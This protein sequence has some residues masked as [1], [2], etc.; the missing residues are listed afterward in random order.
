MYDII[1]PLHSYLAFAALALL[2]WATVNGF[3]G[4]SANRVF[5]EKDRK[6]NL[7]ALI[8]THTM[9]LLGI[10]LLIISPMAESAFKDMGAT[11]KNSSLRSAVVEHPIINIIAAALVTVG[12]AKSK[13]G[14]NNGA[15][16]KATWLFYGLG[17][18]LILS[19]IPYST[20]LG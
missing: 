18:L 10:I 8:A 13:R 17:L 19:R 14:L 12:N 3:I 2:V 7:F 15:K 6:I 5:N 4:A 1:K 9:L 11:M 16:F 20:W